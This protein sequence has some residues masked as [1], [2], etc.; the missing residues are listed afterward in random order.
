MNNMRFTDVVGEGEDKT[1]IGTATRIVGEVEG[2]HDIHLEGELEGKV[3]LNALLTIG[4]KGRLKGEVVADNVIVEGNVEGEVVAKNNI[5]I[6]T[7]GSFKGDI[8][9]KKIAIADGAYFQGSVKMEDGNALTP[10]YFK[11]KRQDLK[12]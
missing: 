11:E 5:E 8:A 6:R 4:E 1:F 10:T 7:T 3:R 2:D 9:C 12:K